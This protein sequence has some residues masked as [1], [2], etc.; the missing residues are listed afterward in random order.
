MQH[1]QHV[2]ALH[3]RDVWSLF[4]AVTYGILAVMVIA[5]LGIVQM[6]KQLFYRYAVT[7]KSLG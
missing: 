4:I 3:L 1:R 2:P 5:Y 7:Q 6:G